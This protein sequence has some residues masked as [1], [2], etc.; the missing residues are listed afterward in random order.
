MPFNKLPCLSKR[1][2]KCASCDWKGENLR[3]H[4]NEKHSEDPLP[5]LCDKC[6][7]KTYSQLNLSKHVK[8]MHERKENFKCENCEF[9]TLHEG[10]ENIEDLNFSFHITLAKIEIIYPKN[11]RA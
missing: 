8:V 11:V 1:I 5:F 6:D 2:R 3:I 10:L 7:H 9:E 4:W